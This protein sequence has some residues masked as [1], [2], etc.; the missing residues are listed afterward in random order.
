MLWPYT[1][2]WS[3]QW[4]RQTV[5]SSDRD[6]LHQLKLVSTLAELGKAVSKPHA[7]RQNQPNPDTGIPPRVA[8]TNS[9]PIS[10]SRASRL[11]IV[12]TPSAHLSQTSYASNCNHAHLPRPRFPLAAF[13]HPHPH[14]PA[15]PR[16]CSP[17]MGRC[18]RDLRHAAQLLLLALRLP[19]AFEP[20][21]SLVPTAC[22]DGESDGGR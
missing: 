9:L 15:R 6:K 7:G 14:H 16:R 11:S 21:S 2:C 1:S 8:V 17:R 22:P 5:R 3:I 19:A 12:L 20:A 13:K 10:N 4:L 18:T